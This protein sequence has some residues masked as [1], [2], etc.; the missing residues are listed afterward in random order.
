MP[1]R[2]ARLDHQFR[3]HH[4][5]AGI[6]LRGLQ[7]EGVAA[8]D[9]RRE[10]PHRDHRREVEG[11]DA[12]DDAQRLAHRIDIDAGAGAVRIFAL[13][14]MRDAGRELAD[15]QAALDV[16]LGVRHRLAVFAREQ[17]G[18]R[19]HVAVQKLDELHHDPGAPLWV[20]G[21]PAG[22]RRLGVLDRLAH[23]RFGGERHAGGDFARHGREHIAEAPR[24]ALHMLAADEMGEFLHDVLA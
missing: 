16:A 23:L 2:K 21:S 18:E 6:A 4:R 3:Q 8:G 17:V 20:D 5:H 24:R 1:G 15:F 19:I 13:H 10:F 7:D 9:R 12:G 14:Q 22:L 11:R